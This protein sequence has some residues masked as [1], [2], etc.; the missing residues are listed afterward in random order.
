MATKCDYDVAATSDQWRLTMHNNVMQ[1]HEDL[2]SFTGP[3]WPALP[4]AI[5][6]AV[7]GPAVIDTGRESGAHPPA[8]SEPFVSGPAAIGRA[9]TAVIAF[10]GLNALALALGVDGDEIALA[11]MIGQ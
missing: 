9:G 7:S 5:G 6:L 1:T 10:A 11:S 4:A 8:V 3:G 2:P